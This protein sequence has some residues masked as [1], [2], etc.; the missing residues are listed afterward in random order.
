MPR[1]SP[2]FT[3]GTSLM[4]ASAWAFL[5]SKALFRDQRNIMHQRITEFSALTAGMPQLHNPFQLPI[6]VL[7]ARIEKLLEDKGTIISSF[8]YPNPDSPPVN[9][10]VITALHQLPQLQILQQ[11]LLQAFSSKQTD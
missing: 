1:H 3:A 7:N 6:F 2:A 9:R 4:P 10:I 5:Q 11:Q 8:G